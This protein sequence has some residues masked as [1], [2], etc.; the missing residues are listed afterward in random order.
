MSTPNSRSERSKQPDEVFC[1]SCGEPIK[2]RAER[3]PHCGVG[4]RSLRATSAG[5]TDTPDPIVAAV[6]SLFIPGAG[7]LYNGEVVLGISMFVGYLI[8]VGIW[9]GLL[10]LFAVITLGLGAVLWVFWPAIFLLNPLSAA[11]SYLRAKRIN[12][13]ELT[14]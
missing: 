14:P 7:D 12:A 9:T 13:G 3:C 8:V 5:S 2:R 1:E 4:R 11:F 10:F 6:A